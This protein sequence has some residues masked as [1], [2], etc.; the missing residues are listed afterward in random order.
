MKLW[1]LFDATLIVACEGG[2]LALAAGDVFDFYQWAEGSNLIPA[3]F[4]VAMAI[5]LRIMS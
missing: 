3:T 4:L 2:A 1:Q 5:R